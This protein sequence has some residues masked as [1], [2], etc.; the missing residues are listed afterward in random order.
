MNQSALRL[1]IR[2]TVV[3]RRPQALTVGPNLDA[4]SLDLEPWGTLGATATPPLSP[5]SLPTRTPALK[6]PPLPPPSPLPP[7]HH[8][9]STSPPVPMAVAEFETGVGGTDAAPNGE[10]SDLAAEGRSS[11]GERIERVELATSVK[12]EAAPDAGA[13]EDPAA[14]PITAGSRDGS[15][16]EWV[17]GGDFGYAPDSPGGGTVGTVRSVERSAM[18]MHSEAAFKATTT[19]GMAMTSA[20]SDERLDAAVGRTVGANDSGA[21][22]GDSSELLRASSATLPRYMQPRSSEVA[23]GSDGFDGAST[24]PVHMRVSTQTSEVLRILDRLPSAGLQVREL[25]RRACARRQVS[26]PAPS[27]SYSDCMSAFETHGV[28]LPLHAQEVRFMFAIFRRP[29]IAT[30]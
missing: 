8:R 29:A 27:W 11:P 14:T 9:S 6:S 2:G 17:T 18:M 22:P 23:P 26:S 25:R 28:L 4:S 10:C 21:L 3:A 7:L 16:Y 19:P 12:I 15:P 1:Q 5:P 20:L 24:A 13:I 30:D